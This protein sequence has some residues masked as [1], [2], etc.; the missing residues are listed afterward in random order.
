MT[1]E[2]L[3]SLNGT[4]INGTVLRPGEAMALPSG[5]RVTFGDVEFLVEFM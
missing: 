5:S 3:N 2:D 4:T 1:I